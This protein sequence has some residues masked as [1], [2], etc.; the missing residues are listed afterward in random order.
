M[1]VEDGEEHEEGQGNWAVRQRGNLQQDTG[2]RCGCYVSG[3]RG[4]CHHRGI[5]SG[6]G[7]DLPQNE[8]QQKEET[9]SRKSNQ[10]ED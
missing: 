4:Q 6:R 1:K 5:L 10:D 9:E 7:E 2:A 3:A 8:M